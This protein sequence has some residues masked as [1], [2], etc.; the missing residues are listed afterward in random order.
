VKECVSDSECWSKQTDGNGEVVFNFNAPEASGTHTI[1]A[2]CDGCS[3]TATKPVDVKVSDL[4]P[5]PGSVYYALVEDG[6][7]KVIGD[8][9]NHS[10][11]HYLTSAASMKL[12][13]V[14]RDFYEYQI[15]KSVAIPTLLHLNDASL[16]WGGKFDVAGKWTGYHFKHDRGNVIDVRANTTVGF[17]PEAYFTDF[18]NMAADMGADAQLHCSATSDPSI[19]NCA[20][21]ENR[22]YHVILK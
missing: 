20:G 11:N 9:G 4:W 8:N 21:D 6:S 18:E 14:A 22:H 17:I 13:R 15:Q 16:K 2:T 3:N 19:D 5:I 1:S 12:W 7:S 10:G